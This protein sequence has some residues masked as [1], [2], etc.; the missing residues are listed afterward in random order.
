MKSKIMP[1][2]VLGSICLVAALLL[3]VVNMF[4]A[5]LIEANQAAAASGAFAEV[6]PGAAG[7]QDLTIDDSY[8]AVVK[9]GYKFD[10]G[11]VFQM[12][13]SGWSSGLVIMCGIGNDGKITGMKHIKTSDTYG[14]EPELNNAY[15]GKDADTAELIIATGATPKSL[16]SKGYFEAVT[17]ALQ[18]YTVASGGS[19]DLRSPLDIKCN[20]ALGTETLTFV[21]WFAVEVLDGVSAVYVDADASA[22]VYVVGET[23]IGIFADG[24]IA[25]TNVSA[26]D[27]AKALEADAIVKASNSTD[28]TSEL[29]GAVDNVT[30]V[31]KTDSGNYIIEVLGEGYKYE[32][33]LEFVG[34]EEGQIEIKVAISADGK[35]IDVKTMKH[36]E[37]NGYG[38]ACDSEEYYE[39]FRGANDSDIVVTVPF[40]DFHDDQIPAEGCTDIGAIANSTFTSTGYQAAIKDAFAAFNLLNTTEGGND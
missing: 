30:K 10:N 20:D 8:P 12:E 39:Q 13:V 4:T 33:N 9:A 40:P 18:A 21:K 1:S 35:I 32:S 31:Y 29:G 24:T 7:Q 38:S 22:R 34:V 11:Y 6:L 23:Y 37:T 27:Q 2:L 15:I 19:V 17:A 26:E 28:I 3:S 5:P 25:T 14:L 16:T 36:Q